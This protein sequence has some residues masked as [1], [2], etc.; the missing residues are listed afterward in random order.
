M[1]EIIGVIKFAMEKEN[2]VRAIIEIAF[3]MTIG[4]ILFLLIIR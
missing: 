4:V 2:R 3:C 1:R